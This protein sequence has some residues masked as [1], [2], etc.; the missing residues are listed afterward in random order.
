MTDNPKMR[1]GSFAFADADRPIRAPYKFRDSEIGRWNASFRQ[2]VPLP[3]H[4]FSP[5]MSATRREM[6]AG[7][8]WLGVHHAGEIS[9]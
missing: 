7:R 6:R 1:A 8:R 5:K 3:I 9:V 4:P 2:V